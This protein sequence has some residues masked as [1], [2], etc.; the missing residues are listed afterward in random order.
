MTPDFFW[1]RDHLEKLYVKTCAYLEVG[2]RTKVWSLA[3]YIKSYVVIFWS[4]HVELCPGLVDYVMI[5][6]KEPYIKNEKS[7][8]DVLYL[9]S[10]LKCHRFVQKQLLKLLKV[11][12]ALTATVS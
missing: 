4:A 6:A 1:D 10:G 7:T 3:V 5:W 9:K 11:L 8:I 12:N 2:K